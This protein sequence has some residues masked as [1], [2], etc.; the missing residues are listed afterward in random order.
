MNSNQSVDELTDYLMSM[1]INHSTNSRYPIKSYPSANARYGAQNGSGS[2]NSRYGQ[3]SKQQK[4]L[5]QKN[6]YF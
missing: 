5:K 4:E 1:K 2:A 6:R 3:K